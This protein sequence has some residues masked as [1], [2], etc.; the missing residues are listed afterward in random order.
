MPN[1][2]FEGYIGIYTAW[3][4]GGDGILGSENSGEPG[5]QS[6]NLCGEEGLRLSRQEGGKELSLYLAGGGGE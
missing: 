1:L 3:R 5:D 6:R 2:S 4:S